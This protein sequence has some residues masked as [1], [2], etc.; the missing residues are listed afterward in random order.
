MG[1]HAVSGNSEPWGS[2]FGEPEPRHTLFSVRHILNSMC[3]TLNSMWLGSGS[4]K[5]CRRVRICLPQRQRSTG[6]LKE[7]ARGDGPAEG[8]FLR[9]ERELRAASSESG[10]CRG[11]ALRGAPR[12]RVRMGLWLESAQGAQGEGRAQDGH[13]RADRGSQEK[14]RNHA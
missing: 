1:H 7:E 11:E 5:C 2:I 4:P 12:A 10:C 8:P 3:H 14:T 13:L 6:T 9:P